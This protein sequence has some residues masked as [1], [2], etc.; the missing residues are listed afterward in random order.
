MSL[1]LFGEADRPIGEACPHCSGILAGFV[2]CTLP[3]TPTYVACHRS[4]WGQPPRCAYLP[5]D[6][7]DE[8]RRR[9]IEWLAE[10]SE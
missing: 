7:S 1:D 8:A 9:R 3:S 6:N 5:V 4:V 10:N 2:R